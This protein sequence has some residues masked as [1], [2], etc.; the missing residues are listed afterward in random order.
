MKW[1]ET[2]KNFIIKN[3]DI[4]PMKF[5]FSIG[6]TGHIT[7]YITNYRIISQYLR[8]KYLFFIKFHFYNEFLDFYFHITL[9]LNIQLWTFDKQSHYILFLPKPK[10][11][12][13][14]IILLAFQYSEM[15]S[16]SLAR[17]WSFRYLSNIIRIDPIISI[18][19]I[20]FN[21]LRN[22]ISSRSLNLSFI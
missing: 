14:L 8:G 22:D 16:Y 13:T 4:F 15:T 20:D 3:D 1:K 21:L 5:N 6:C 9:C 7:N 12:L 2:T 11:L 18:V 10:Y 19:L 17:S